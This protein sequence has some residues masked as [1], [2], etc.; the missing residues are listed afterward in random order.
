MK[1]VS[2]KTSGTWKCTETYKALTQFE[3]D[4]ILEFKFDFGK[5]LHEVLATLSIYDSGCPYI[6]HPKLCAI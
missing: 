2:G 5:Q 4:T 6:H 1:Y 3:V